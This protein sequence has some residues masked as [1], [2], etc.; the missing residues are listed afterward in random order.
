MEILN[1]WDTFLLGQCNLKVRKRL[2]SINE[3]AR[4]NI[5]ILNE[6]L[7]SDLEY[8]SLRNKLDRVK[9][10]FYNGDIFDMPCDRKFDNINLSNVNDYYNRE[11]G[12]KHIN[13]MYP[14]LNDD[15]CLGTY[16]YLYRGNVSD[17]E[18]SNLYDEVNFLSFIA[19]YGIRTNN[20]SLRD[21]MIMY[22]KVKKL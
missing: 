20:Y 6:Y 15:G 16:M 9:I 12:I 5:I 14:L 19:A 4:N 17:Y 13:A 10:D 22:K 18:L 2:F 3:I 8:E 11:I 21:G 1:F 7:K